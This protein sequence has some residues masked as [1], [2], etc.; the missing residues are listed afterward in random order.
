MS[1]L[2]SQ[3]SVFTRSKMNFILSLTVTVLLI[4]L[5]NG[6]SR[7]CP[8]KPNLQ[9]NLCLDRLKLNSKYRPI[10]GK[11]RNS[12]HNLGQSFK[13]YARF[14]P[15]HYD[16][17]IWSFRRAVSGEELPPPRN[18]V[19]NVLRP[20]HRPPVLRVPNFLSAMFGQYI[21]HDIGSKQD[22]ATNLKCCTADRSK[23]L[24][25]EEQDKSCM[26]IVIP[27]ND[28]DYGIEFP[29]IGCMSQGIVRSSNSTTQQNL[30]TAVDQLNQN[31]AFLDNSNVYGS[32]EEVMQSLR[33]FQGGRMITNSDNILPEKNGVYFLGDNRLTQTPQLTQIHSIYLR[34]HNRI[35]G[36]LGN[37]NPHWSD[38]KLF[39]EARRINI[40]QFQ[41]IIYHEWLPTYLSPETVNLINN[42]LNFYLQDAATYNE[43]N[44]AV[45]R[46]LHTIVPKDIQF[47]A[48]DGSIR[49]ESL[50]QQ[51]FNRLTKTNY[52]ETARGLLMQPINTGDFSHMFHG[53]FA[54]AGFIGADLISMDINRGRDH[55]LPPYVDILQYFYNPLGI[56]SFNRFDDLKPF[57][58]AENLNLL[59]K[60]YKS[61]LD[62][63]LFVGTLLEN[64]LEGTLLGPTTQLMFARQFYRLKKEDPYFYSNY[65]SPNP[66]SAQQLREIKKATTNH[67]FCLNSAV[68]SIPR[69]PL[70]APVSEADRV[71]CS[72]LET[73]SY[74]SWKD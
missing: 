5:A 63:D 9:I 48:Q 23:P 50:Y 49:T 36:I 61:V 20:L 22:S 28:P 43:F 14:V 12:C 56:G 1:L 51:F 8:A 13:S 11:L 29:T 15:A 25:L 19:N 70:I 2:S 16:D 72:S 4:S 26:P 74:Q 58:N 31:T 44:H 59:K 33:E 27:P 21:A 57:I 55:G 7:N 3:S 42:P 62:V 64:P 18:I 10:D 37:L 67:L 39:E 34:E 52:E 17:C 41:H 53:L 47:I 30:R 66:L 35:A 45:F 46:N 73:I 71:S 68:S 38:S 60:N 24:P 65:M 32:T 40:A 54:P 6:D 69:E